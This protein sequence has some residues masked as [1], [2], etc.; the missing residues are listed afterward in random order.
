MEPHK[1][2]TEQALEI[3]I[4]QTIKHND[5]YQKARFKVS[6]ENL[7]KEMFNKFIIGYGTGILQNQFGNGI[8]VIDEMNRNV[9]DQLYFYITSNELKFKGDIKKGILLCGKYGT[10]KSVLMKSYRYIVNWFYRSSFWDGTKPE[11][12]KPT[13][14]GPI[15]MWKSTELLKKILKDGG[16][17]DS[18][19]SGQNPILIDDLGLEP[20]SAN[21]FGTP[22]LPIVDLLLHRYDHG[23]LTFATSNFN[24]TDLGE[25]YG[26]MIKDRLDS[27]FNFMVLYGESRRK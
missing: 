24:K 14:P 22:I 4:N 10:G 11:A 8:F 13:F 17:L 19:I 7:N 6:E 1:I 12:T 15:S 9:I 16:E 21:I 20:V 18:I 25:R 2:E 26:C 3:L 5:N 27:M 23:H